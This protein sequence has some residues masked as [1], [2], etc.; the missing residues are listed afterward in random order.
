MAASELKEIIKKVD[1]ESESEHGEEDEMV[2][3][4]IYRPT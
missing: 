1:T 4:N 3:P 2:T